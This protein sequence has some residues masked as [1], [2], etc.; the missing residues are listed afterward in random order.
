MTQTTAN[1][2][3]RDSDRYTPTPTAGFCSGFRVSSHP[4]FLIV[5]IMS[6]VFSS[7]F[8]HPQF[9]VCYLFH[10]DIFHFLANSSHHHRCIRLPSSLVSCFM[11]LYCCYAPV[12]VLWLS[13]SLHCIS[14][15]FRA[16]CFYG[17]C[18]VQSVVVLCFRFCRV[19][20]CLNCLP[21]DNLCAQ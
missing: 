12:S 5:I 17:L 15:K 20:P 3:T 19:A 1:E 16:L 13:C 18:S 14:S 7:S 21:S 4:V 10:L 11:Q 2:R 9:S 6:F 8:C